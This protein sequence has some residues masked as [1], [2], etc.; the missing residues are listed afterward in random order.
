MI[1]F[2][3]LLRWLLRHRLVEFLSMFKA[4]SLISKVAIFSIKKINNDSSLNILC[5]GRAIFDEEIEE[6]SN[7]S[8][9]LNYLVIPKIIFISIFQFHF[10]RKI[11]DHINYHN[12]KNLDFEKIEYKKFLDNFLT[13]LFKEL[14]IDAMM[15][16]NYVY[17]WQQEL[18][19]IC[20][21]RKIP[22]VILH[23]EGMTSPSQ[24]K[25]L[26]DTYTN[27]KFIGS[28]ML[29]YN[30][31][32]KN[33]LIDANIKGITK[34]NIVTV[35]VPRFDKYSSIGS[36]G[37]SVVFFSFYMEDKLRH[38][39][40][41]ETTKSELLQKSINFHLEIMKFAKQSQ[42]LN[43]TIKTKGGKR[44]LDYVLNI[45]KSNQL[46]N[47]H[48]LKIINTGTPYELIQDAFLVG[49]LNSSVLLEAILA[50]RQVFMPNFKNSLF[51]DYFINNE[52]LVNYVNSYEDLIKCINEFSTYEYLE[53]RNDLFL[54][55][56][57]STPDG[58]S[59]IRAEN[60][61]ISVIKNKL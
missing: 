3:F 30:D 39:S 31:N 48:N 57:I 15:S 10:H 1:F 47:L 24:Y 42:H 59:S 52:D 22:F 29:V 16:A 43:V 19:S 61:I 49:G 23:K 26:V 34:N 7:N 35:G 8:S 60:E 18:A 25:N 11:F 6:L 32:I 20:L 41:P 58:M 17:S 4:Y 9:K 12:D 50:K 46:E 27:G 53:E 37:S 55:E 44:Y 13:I 51:E 56:F 28:R 45:A 54:K 40:L 36:I 2:S 5:I 38:I 33:A 14:N 21:E